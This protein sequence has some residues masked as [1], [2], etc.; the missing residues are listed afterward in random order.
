[1]IIGLLQCDHVAEDLQG[2]Y[3]NYDHMFRQFFGSI[4]PHWQFKI[5]K[6]IEGHFPAT[7]EECDAYIATGSKASVYDD[8]EWILQTKRFIQELYAKSIKYVGICFGHQLLAESLGGKVEK[9][10]EFGWNVGVHTFEILQQQP[11]MIPYQQYVSLL[12]MC[13]DQVVSLPDNSTVIGRLATCPVGMFQVGNTALGIQAHPEFPASYDAELIQRRIDRI[14]IEKAEKALESI[15]HIPLNSY[16][17]GEW[18][19]QFIES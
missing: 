4:A 15:Q 3:G 8:E 5:Y 7:A 1:M 17:V 14:G 11:W 10:F 12:M 16:L 13:Q 19:V 6:V 18:V 9:S 2:V